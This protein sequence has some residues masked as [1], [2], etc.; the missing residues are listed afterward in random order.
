VTEPDAPTLHAFTPPS[1]D[2]AG[3]PAGELLYTAIAAA[4]HDRDA[5]LLFGDSADR[6]AAEALGVRNLWLA[7][8]PGGPGARRIIAS[9]V[10]AALRRLARTHGPNACTLCW[11]PGLRFLQS[12]SAALFAEPD[13]DAL[14]AAAARLP[15][16]HAA[17]EA[18]GLADEPTIAPLSASPA[19]VD[20][21]AVAFV[22]GVLDLLGHHHTLLLPDTS[23]R[24]EE[25]LR[26][27][28]RTELHTRVLLVR[29][30]LLRALPAADV[31]IEPEYT[32][33]DLDTPV[34]HALRR[35]AESLGAPVASTHGWDTD[36]GL[37]HG[38]LPPEIGATVGPAVR[39]LQRLARATPDSPRLR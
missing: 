27:I 37:G 23:R 28:R 29:P 18:L 16:R 30:P 9:T 12:R 39:A 6:R 36:R 24:L 17:R 8:K 32:P 35:L 22:S 38:N 5:A 19:R 34:P 26:F 10:R 2:G 4:R 15:S 20:A 11:S 13:T 3:V 21:R 14:A 1:P 31:L 33:A 25:G 7:R